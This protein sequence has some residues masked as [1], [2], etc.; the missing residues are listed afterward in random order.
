M[1]Q[2]GTG[3][4]KNLPTR[5]ESDK[6]ATRFPPPNYIRA[7]AKIPCETKNSGLQGILT[8]RK[9]QLLANSLSKGPRLA[10]GPRRAR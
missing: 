8:W 6:A 3:L 1:T 7:N 2:A 4:R 9:T 10:F 5:L